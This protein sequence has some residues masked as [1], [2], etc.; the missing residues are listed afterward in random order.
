M[1][2]KIKK[3]KS[4][5]KKLKKIVSLHVL[6]QFVKCNFIFSIILYIIDHHTNNFLIF[7]QI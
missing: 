2:I 4:V 1:L 3:L 7:I 5:I 6:T